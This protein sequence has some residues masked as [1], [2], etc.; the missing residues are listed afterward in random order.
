MLEKRQNYLSIL[1]TQNGITKSLLCEEAIKEYAAKN[2]GKK[3]IVEV[4]KA[5]T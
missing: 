1:F 3:S 4:H 5:V 2:V